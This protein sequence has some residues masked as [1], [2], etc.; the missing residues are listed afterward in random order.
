MLHVLG[1]AVE[2][3]LRRQL[4]RGS[5]EDQKPFYPGLYNRVSRRMPFV[6]PVGVGG[7]VSPSLVSSFARLD[8]VGLYGILQ[9][10]RARM[11]WAGARLWFVVVGKRILLPFAVAMA[12]I[13]SYV[14]MYRHSVIGQHAL[15][16]A[17]PDRRCD[18]LRGGRIDEKRPGL[19]DEHHSWTEISAPAVLI[20]G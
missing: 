14:G 12:S 9:I 2:T 7:K 16:N 5:I 18:R 13:E 11:E 6:T 8:V 15:M 19:E 17:L 1:S 10:I 4:G 20:G 3:A